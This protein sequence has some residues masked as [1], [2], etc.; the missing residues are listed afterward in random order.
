MSIKIKVKLYAMLK[1]QVGNDSIDLELKGPATLRT[2][3]DRLEKEYPAVLDFRD[4]LL[5]ARGN[6]YLVLESP[7]EEGDILSLYPPISGG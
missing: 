3:F 5:V 4:H 2:L 7:L 1:E 6:D